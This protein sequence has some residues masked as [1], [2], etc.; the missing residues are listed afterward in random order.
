MIVTLYSLL[1]VAGIVNLLL[2]VYALYFPFIPRSRFTVKLPVHELRLL[3]GFYLLCVCLSVCT[4]LDHY[5][6]PRSF[7]TPA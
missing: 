3:A 4:S 1:A 7:L 6:M 5:C 2:K